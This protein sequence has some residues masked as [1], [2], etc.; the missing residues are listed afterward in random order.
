MILH[1]SKHAYTRPSLA[2]QGQPV[3][4]SAVLKADNT[5]PISRQRVI[6]SLG[7]QSCTGATDT[8]GTATCRINSVSAPLGKNTATAS[9]AGDAFYPPAK[10]NKQALIFAFL[11]RG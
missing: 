3:T 5:T 1:A 9:F 11:S 2:T 7:S 6:V 4:L 8:S 10:D